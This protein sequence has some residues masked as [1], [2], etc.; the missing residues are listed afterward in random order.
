MDF[1]EVCGWIGSAVVL[2]AFGLNS[3]EI[4]KTGTLYK[5]LNVLAAIGLGLSAWRTHNRPAMWLEVVWGA[6]ALI[7]ILKPGKKKSPPA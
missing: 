3:W 7:G 2:V 4:L 1:Y 5:S 6:I